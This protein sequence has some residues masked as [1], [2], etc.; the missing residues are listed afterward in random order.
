[1]QMPASRIQEKHSTCPWRGRFCESHHTDRFVVYV[2]LRTPSFVFSGTWQLGI[3][4]GKQCD[5]MEQCRDKVEEK[6]RLVKSTEMS[7]IQF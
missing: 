3:K 1:M 4:D 6:K 5:R 7:A 2:Q